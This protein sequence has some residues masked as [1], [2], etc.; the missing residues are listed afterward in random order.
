MIRKNFDFIH[1]AQRSHLQSFD[2]WDKLVN[3][4]ELSE[5]KQEALEK[6]AIVK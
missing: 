2:V 6:G 4:K 1:K 5:E 3:G